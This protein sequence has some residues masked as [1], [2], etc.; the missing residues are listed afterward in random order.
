M[1]GPSLLV[2]PSFV[3]ETELSEYYLP[4]GKWTSFFDPSRVIEGPL[5]MKEKVNLDDI[6]LWVREGSALALGPSGVDR[7]DYSYIT[8]LELRIYEAK[9]GLELM[10]EIPSSAE[11]QFACT[12]AVK[13][14][15]HAVRASFDTR[16]IGVRC[17]KVYKGGQVF[18][19]ISAG[20][21]S[22]SLEVCIA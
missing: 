6:A 3:P 8:D 9:P 19:S 1:L 13:S 14:Y 4:A 22:G 11:P 5:W 10:I 21:N 16:P 18:D 15:D 20:N 17:M 7:P 2:A 12:I